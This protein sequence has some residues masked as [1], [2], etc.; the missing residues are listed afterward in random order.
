[1]KKIISLVLVLLMT[2]VSVFAQGA[3]PEFLKQMYTNYGAD[4][5]VSF[6]FDNPEE[7]KE[8]LWEVGIG[9]SLE[10]F[11]DAEALM[12]TLL[13]SESTMNLK[14][15]MSEDL[16]DI[17][18]SMSSDSSQYIEVNRNL[19]MNINS[20]Y[21]MWIDM[22]L[23][24]KDNVEFDIIYDMP[25]MNKYLVISE[26]D[27][28]KDQVGEMYELLSMV[29]NK[30]FIE[31][32][33]EKVAETYTEY[34][35]I[36]KDGDNY[37][38]TLGNDAFVAYMEDVFAMVFEEMKTDV[39]LPSFKGMKLLGENGIVCEVSLKDGKI[40]A[41]KV[42]VDISIDLPGI[43]KAMTGNEWEYSSKGIL[44]FTFEIS[45]NMSG[46]GT[47]KVDFPHLSDG[48]YI[49]I[50]DMEPN[51]E[52][53]EGY[54]EEYIAEYP[55]WYAGDYSKELPKVDGNIYVPLRRTLES[56]YEDTVNLEYHNGIITAKSTFFRGFDTVIVELDKDEVMLDG[57]ACTVGKP[58]V[59]D[60]TTYINSKLFTEHFGWTLEEATHNILTD[61]YY[62]S[63]FTE[64]W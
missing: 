29:L 9:E 62:Y 5:T 7:V 53:Y 32:V 41:E 11:V 18:L 45:A 63:F 38:I 10:Y 25:F 54:E 44:D 57:K 3:A 51:R 28:E 2:S 52:N 61:E 21:A 6:S 1:M 20:K 59:I 12:K 58:I 24:D 22:N 42:V 50:A 39:E 26:A 19:N 47:T 43:Y 46:Y 4:Y 64:N 14:A 31:S 8:L 48:D 56:A 37:T 27:M 16:K 35:D 33:N 49:T 55:L 30:E 17:R 13:S 36:K 34:A 15:D 23:K 40:S 60:G